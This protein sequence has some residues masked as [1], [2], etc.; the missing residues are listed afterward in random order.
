[1]MNDAVDGPAWIVCNDEERGTAAK[2][3]ECPYRGTVDLRICLGCRY[4]AG[5][6][7]DRRRAWCEPNPSGLHGAGDTLGPA[8]ATAA[9]TTPLDLCVE[10]L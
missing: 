10:L 7:S 1:M 9:A 5:M 2:L 4:L 3:V 8:T 6:D